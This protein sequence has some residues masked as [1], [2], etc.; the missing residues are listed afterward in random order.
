MNYESTDVFLETGADISV[1]LDKLIYTEQLT[2]DNV[3]LKVFT[4]D[5]VCVPTAVVIMSIG[6]NEFK[7]E[8]VVMLRYMMSDCII[9]AVS[10]DTTK[11]SGLQVVKKP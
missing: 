10:I 5:K 2:R 3:Y 6:D 4:G 8:V 7:E 1:V 9:L 11:A